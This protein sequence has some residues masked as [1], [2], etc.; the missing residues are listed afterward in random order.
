MCGTEVRIRS[1]IS[2]APRSVS[3]TPVVSRPKPSTRGANP[4]ETM[5][6]SAVSVSEAEPSAD[7]MSTSTPLP[8]PLSRTAVVLCPVF[9]VTPSFLYCLAISL[10]TSASSFGRT[11]SMNSTTVTSTPKFDST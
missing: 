1:S 5:T 3:A 7:S 11:R 4:M 9:S 10:E 2:I 6:R 8:S